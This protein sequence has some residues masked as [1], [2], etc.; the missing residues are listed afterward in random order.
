MSYPIFYLAQR[1]PLSNPYA[2][3]H[4][5]KQMAHIHFYTSPINPHHPNPSRAAINQKVCH[6]VHRGHIYIHS[7]CIHPKQG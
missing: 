1:P 5:A 4:T 6:Y 2:R 7:R 3:S